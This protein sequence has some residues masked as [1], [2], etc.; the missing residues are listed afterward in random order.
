M[1]DTESSGRG[2]LSIVRSNFIPRPEDMVYRHLTRT[3]DG[4]IDMNIDGSAGIN[5][6][7]QVPL[8]TVYKQFQLSR[9]NITIVDTGMRND[10][11][12]GLAAALV[13]GVLFQILDD[14]GAVT[15]HFDTDRSPVTVNSAFACLAGI[16]AIIE[17]AAGPDMIPVRWSLLKA[18]RKIQMLPGEIFRT[19]IQD[20]L[21]ALDVFR[22]CIQGVL[23]KFV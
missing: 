21:A 16:D 4:T 13:N 18:G 6:D 15:Q 10:R 5:F 1:P 14:G 8:G 17:P 11:F 22:I 2:Q 7:Y 12:G 20:N 23:L 19:R 3:S 9:V